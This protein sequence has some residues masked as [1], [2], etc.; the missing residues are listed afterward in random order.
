MMFN[1]GFSRKCD[2]KELVILHFVVGPNI[3]SFLIGSSLMY[4]SH[5]KMTCMKS[6]VF[7][8]LL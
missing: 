4:I 3:I 2:G 5:K 6:I 8:E 7:N 1:F